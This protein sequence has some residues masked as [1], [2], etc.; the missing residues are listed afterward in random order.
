MNIEI[1]T[2]FEASIELEAFKSKEY[3]GGLKSHSCDI[4]DWYGGDICRN[5]DLSKE[6]SNI[7]D[8]DK[9]YKIKILIEQV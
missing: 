6:L 4:G 2:K 1:N 8:N 9:K 7:L 3:G 5:I